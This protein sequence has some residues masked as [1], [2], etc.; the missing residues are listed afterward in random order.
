MKR[1]QILHVIILA[2]CCSFAISSNAKEGMWLP[3]LLKQL[4]EGEMQSMGMKLSAEDIYS[5]NQSS[6]KDAVLIFGG[7]CT[8][9]L[10]SNQGLL[11][12]NHHCGYG[13]IQSH[14]SVEHDYLTDGFW[15]MSKEEELPNLGLTVTFIISMEDVTAQLQ[16]S[17]SK[18]MGEDER[19]AAIRRISKRITT[20][21]EEGT[22][23]EA[24]IRPFYHGNQ[25]VL[26]ITET[27][28]DVRLVGAPP[29]SVGKFGFDTDN[30]VWPR[31]TGD[32][33]MFRIYADSNNMP[34]EYS[35]NNIPFTPRH[36]LPIQTNG[37]KEDDFTMV[38][39]FPGR[40]EEYLPSPAVSYVLDHGNPAK[41]SMRDE[42]LEIIGKWMDSDKKINIQYAAKQSRISNAWKKWIG[43][44]KGLKQVDAIGQKQVLE[45]KFQTAVDGN[46]AWKAEYGSV[47][48][49]YNAVYDKAVPYMLG[50]DLLIEYFYYGPEIIRFASRFEAL[51]EEGLSEEK[52]Q[53]IVEKLKAA[54]KGHFK[55]YQKSVDEELFLALSKLYVD[56]LNPDFVPVQLS[57]ILNSKNPVAEL[58]ENTIFSSEE[59]VMDFLENFSAKQVKKLQKDQ[60]YILQK[61]VLDTY[62]SKIKPKYDEYNNELSLLNRTYMKGLMEVLPNEQVY[63]PD[64]NF[65]LRVTYG[66]VNGY[67][68]RDGV[69]YEFYT[70]A[71]GILE[72]MNNSTKEFAV[73][74]KLAGLIREK[75]FGNYADEN[76]DLRVCFIGSNHTTGGNSGSPAI[77]ANGEL[78]GLNFDRTWESTMSDVMYDATICRNIMVDIRYVLFI[79]DEYAEA[80][81]LID[82]LTLVK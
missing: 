33:S 77:N 59:E 43:Q 62:L 5:V 38:F 24:E 12:T 40:T 39:G 32:F 23:Y 34:A 7:G 53:A 27:Y 8:G 74:E 28:K 64:A 36:H 61:D 75:Q 41:I 48:E 4:N 17:L 67:E 22:H 3:Y 9:E 78:I 10:I 63:Y 2:V 46:P 52:Q 42:S 19:N 18:D 51:A 16:D 30:W 26:I 31:H 58:Y 60:A 15:A 6:L 66:Q 25:F 79:I 81:H 69:E 72:K 57:E 55:N 73:P 54:T 50:R 20:K 11:L 35:P 49:G 82:E 29:S 71:D 21:A 1:L 65:S 14:S 70:T 47:L 80:D 56:N 76:G 45:E 68:P 44:S 13:E 37:Y